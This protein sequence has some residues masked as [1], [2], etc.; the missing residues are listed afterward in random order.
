MF[1]EA[2]VKAAIGNLTKEKMIE[3]CEKL[4]IGINPNDTNKELILS[5]I[6]T[7]MDNNGDKKA[8]LIEI[9][10]PDHDNEIRNMIEEAWNIDAIMPSLDGE[11]TI[12][13]VGDKEVVLA[14]IPVDNRD[15]LAEYL[16]KDK[17]ALALLKKVLA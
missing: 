13:I 3:L 6:Y 9:F 15:A 4:N 5:R 11:K 17:K 8:R 12:V 1:T 7:E 16:T 10:S 2:K 14:D